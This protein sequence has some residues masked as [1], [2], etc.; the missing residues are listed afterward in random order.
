MSAKLRRNG[1][2]G[3]RQ[4]KQQLRGYFIDASIFA[5][6]ASLNGSGKVLCSPVAYMA[7]ISPKSPFRKQTA[8]LCP[9]FAG[10]VLAG[11]SQV[12]NGYLLPFL[13]LS[14]NPDVIFQYKPTIVRLSGACQLGRT[15]F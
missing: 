13:A 6:S 12:A 9:P 14:A 7:E 11:C 2:G 5:Q 1:G 10:P 15:L 3:R 4:K 8:Y